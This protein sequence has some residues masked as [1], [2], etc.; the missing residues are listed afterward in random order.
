MGRG[1]GAVVG[2]AAAP[3]AEPARRCRA[4]AARAAKQL[5]NKPETTVSEALEGLVA[6][7][8]HLGRLDGFPDIKGHERA[9]AVVV[10]G[11]GGA[12]SSG[13]SAVLCADA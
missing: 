3:R 13:C 4:V 1:S 5:I 10:S 6:C 12:V 7:H 11:W 2:K 8:S 9:C